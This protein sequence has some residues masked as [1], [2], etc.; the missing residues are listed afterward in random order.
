M[1]R[2]DWLSLMLK[3]ADPV[4]TNLEAGTLHQNLPVEKPDRAAYAHLEAFG[5]TLTGLAP[6]LELEGLSGEERETQEKTRK[7]VLRC[8]DNA[9][10]PNSPDRM[11]FSEGYGQALVDAAFLAHGILRATKSIVDKLD[12]RVRGNLVDCLKATRVFEPF[13]SNWL[14]FS[15]MVEAALYALGEKWETGPVDRAVDAMEQWYVGDG[16]YS[17]GERFHFDY[18][19]SFVIHPMLVDVLRTLAPVVPRYQELLP[20]AL[21]REARYAAILE[22]MISPEGT[23][24][25]AG[26]S[27]TYRFG[28]F[29]ALAHASLIGNLPPELPANQVRCA[30]SAVLERTARGNLFDENGFLKVGIM[31]SQPGLGEGY[32]CVG[33]AYLCEAVFLS[34]GLPPEHPFW[35]G[36]ETDWTNKKVWSGT[37]VPCDHALD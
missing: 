31:G 36:P 34:L 2:R 17:D 23:Y 6:W 3:I 14:L 25:V 12:D 21:S 13:P 15:A 28:A 35:T 20:K 29:H 33:S 22:R 1:V 19:N 11:N 10:D 27:I 16:M 24:P 8:L 26:R 32:M 18:Y 37:D 5:R 30:L 4:L 9:T 7:T